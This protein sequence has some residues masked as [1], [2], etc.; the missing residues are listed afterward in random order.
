MRRIVTLIALIC[1]LP[2]VSVK[3]VAAQG[4][5]PPV[6]AQEHGFMAHCTDVLS[7]DTIEISAVLE[8]G[9]PLRCLVKLVGISAPDAKHNNLVIRYGSPESH[10]TRWPASSEVARQSQ[11]WAYTVMWD[12]DLL[13][14]FDPERLW[15]EKDRL[16]AVVS[17]GEKNL[18][19]EALKLGWAVLDLRDC[20]V[21]EEEWRN[22]EREAYRFDQG[23]WGEIW[24]TW[25]DDLPNCEL[26]GAIVRE[27]KEG[28]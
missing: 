20:L 1:F 28:L 10:G 18:N 22:A 14:R 15:D 19:L 8:S 23:V 2:L 3:P 27:M 21:N 5:L 24:R 17:Q 6:A 16:T 13:V 26:A 25:V 4:D 11:N 9:H 7:A 12:R